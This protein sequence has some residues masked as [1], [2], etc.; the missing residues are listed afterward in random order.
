MGDLAITVVPVSSVSAP[1]A[2]ILKTGWWSHYRSVVAAKLSAIGIEVLEDD[3]RYIAAHALPRTASGIDRE[4]WPHSRLRTGMVVGS[5]QSGKTASMLGVAA[6]CLDDGVDIIVILAGTRVGL[7]LQTYER[8][9]TQLDGSTP[10]TAW[11]RSEERLILPQPE[12]VMNET[13]AQPIQYLNKPK[14]RTALSKGIPIICVVPKEDAHLLHLARLLKE[15]ASPMFL[16][17]RVQPL[18]MLVLDDEADDASVLDSA[19]S[20]KVTP[21][22]ISALWSGDP[23]ESATRHSNLLATYLAYTATPQANYLQETHN[24][25]APRDLHATL[26]VPGASGA[27]S[28]RNLTYEDPRG[29]RAYYCGG[30]I[31]Y[32]R[33]A[34]SPG[35]LCLTTEFPTP[36]TS[37][38]A[39]AFC[40]RQER[41]RWD[42]LGDALRA[43]LVAG[44]L[45]LIQTERSFS[46]LSAAS[47]ETLEKLKAALPPTHTMLFHPSA[48][49]NDHFHGAADIVRWSLSLPGKES[50][51]AVPVDDLGRTVLTMSPTGLRH[52]LD[53]EEGA[54]RAWLGY[55]E[56]TREALSL[57]P[58]GTYKPI[59]SDLWGT[60][61]A[62]LI[63]DVFPN[64]T[65]RV[66]NSD[67][68]ADDRPQF[69]PKPCDDGRLL[70]PPDIFTIFVAGNVLSRGLTLEGLCISLFLRSASE[71]A[72][73]T[74][75]QMQRWF[76]YRGEHLPFCRVLMFSDQLDLFRRYTVNDTALKWQIMRVMDQSDKTST[77]SMLVLQGAEFVAT[78][79]VDSRRVPLNPGPRPSVKLMQRAKN[80]QFDGNASIL[81]ALLQAGE[82]VGLRGPTNTKRGIIRHA[83]ATLLELAGWLERFRY[84]AHDPDPSSE[85]SQRWA[86]ISKALNIDTPLFQPPGDHPTGYATD[87]Q[88]CPYS[89]AAYLRLWHALRAGHLAPGFYPTDRPRTPWS[90]NDN[91]VEP[92]F[93]LAVR[94]GENLSKEPWLAARGVKAMTRQMGAGDRLSTLWGTR[95]YGEDYYGDEF[96]DYYHHDTKPVPNLHGEASWRPR[97]H[98]GLA[99]F[100]LISDDRGGG[101]MLTVGLSLPHGGPDHI[102]ALR[103]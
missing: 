98:P 15:V 32:N 12:D 13:R 2:P 25:L 57:E 70:P 55:F 56:R 83:P 40:A 47:F 73:D 33:F 41:T 101:D 22:F 81:H 99:L 67:P 1:E 63:D 8:L 77:Q 3:A 27:R 34:L 69:E 19:Q 65:L 54:W 86:N 10:D 30:D 6:L 92:L 9:L 39:D 96:I 16:D 94:F 61:R 60:V 84:E 58:L 24:P 36:K 95:G 59:T 88:S 48:R 71:P 64:V 82:W 100:H 45:R 4:A 80:T 62:I 50:E 7:W 29:V 76:G 91:A 31:F 53:A 42:M 5:V 87:P 18:T 78:S 103:A 26:R 51:T 44:A 68:Q 37:E 20:E 74:Q 43:Y 52:R 49:K 35:R 11:R 97:G 66:L 102:A 38:T 93:Y 17:A 79:K 89:I 23:D 90:F 46:A 14:A 21:R 72:A 85:L 75:M 28:P